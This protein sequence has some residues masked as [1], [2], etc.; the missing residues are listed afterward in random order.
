MSAVMPSDLPESGKSN[1]PP[2]GLGTSFAFKFED[3]KGRI[4]RV[5]SGTEHLEELLS[6]VVQ[7]YEDEEGDKVLLATDGDL[8][9]AVSYARSMGMKM[10]K[11]ESNGEGERRDSIDHLLEETDVPYDEE[12]K[13]SDEESEGESED[14]SFFSLVHYSFSFDVVSK[15]VHLLG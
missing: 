9:A 13:V 8:V 11:S 2:L 15:T 4:H 1:Y 7:R 5:N 14:S 3:L 12:E 10:Y 6:A